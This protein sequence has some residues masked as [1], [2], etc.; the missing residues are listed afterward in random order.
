MKKRDFT[1]VLKENGLKATPQ[2]VL[3][4]ETISRHGHIGIDRLYEEIKGIIP[5]ISIATIYKN[6]KIM[7]EGGIIK[8]ANI[9]SLKN[10][11][12]TNTSFHIHL[13]CRKCNSVFDVHIDKD[14]LKGYLTK[15]TDLRINDIS[16]TLFGY[17]KRCKK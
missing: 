15:V 8:E 16:V 6:L 4:L 3:I 13:L 17:C 9:S 14:K 5:S 2:R 12:E 1:R 10:I 7:E 11:Y